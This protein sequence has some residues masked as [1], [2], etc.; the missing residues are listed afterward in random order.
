ME[1]I[2]VDHS[3]CL[4]RVEMMWAEDPSFF[5]KCSR[6][7]PINTLSISSRTKV[8]Y[9]HPHQSPMKTIPWP[10]RFL[11]LKIW[12]G[13]KSNVGS[14]EL[15]WPTPVGLFSVAIYLV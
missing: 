12:H 4:A 7:L 10:T 5:C 6:R 2:N 3:N 1:I 8:A 11:N 14:R 13:L 9:T 15:L